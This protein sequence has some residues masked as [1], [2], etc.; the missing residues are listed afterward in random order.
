MSIF[1]RY[2]AAFS[3]LILAQSVPASAGA[4]QMRKIHVSAPEAEVF[5]RLAAESLA[6][7]R[8]KRGAYPTAWSELDMTY[9]N[10]PYNINDPDDRPPPDT[11]ELWR[12]KQSNYEYRLTTSTD[13]SAFR[14]DALGTYGQIDYSIRSGDQYPV[15][16]ESTSPD[17]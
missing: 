2:A 1:H 13:G 10:G 4:A 17:R 7:Y 16:V 3:M 15:K 12:P 9:V 8:A 6:D 5:L 11:K 14:I